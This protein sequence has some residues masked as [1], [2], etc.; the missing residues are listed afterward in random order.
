MSDHETN[1]VIVRWCFGLVRIWRMS[2]L[3]TCL[4]KEDD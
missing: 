4:C 3:I 2:I 1:L